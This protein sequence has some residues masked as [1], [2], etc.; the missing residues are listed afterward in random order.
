MS[1]KMTKPGQSIKRESGNNRIPPRPDFEHPNSRIHM[2]INRAFADFLDSTCWKSQRLGEACGF[3]SHQALAMQP[4]T[5]PEFPNPLNYPRMYGINNSSSQSSG[6][7]P[8]WTQNINLH[9]AESADSVCLI[10][11]ESKCINTSFPDFD[12]FQNSKE[13]QSKW[14]MMERSGT[15]PKANP[16]CSRI[17]PP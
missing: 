5:P 6:D 14:K 4:L 1:Q 16:H 7:L 11:H 17:I 9:P 2:A 15:P 3:P 12:L 8:P 10:R 13:T